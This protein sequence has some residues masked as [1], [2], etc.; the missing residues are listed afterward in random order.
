MAR[1]LERVAWRIVLSLA[2]GTGLWCAHVVAASAQPLPFP[3]GYNLFGALTGWAVAMFL[4]ALASWLIGTQPISRIGVI[5]AT[6]ILAVAIELTSILGICAIGILPGPLWKL[7]LIGLGGVAALVGAGISLGIVYVNSQRQSQGWLPQALAA[8]CLGLTVIMA[9]HCVIQAVDWGHHGY[10]KFDSQVNAA[11]LAA[12]ASVGSPVLLITLWLGLLIE[13]R[14]RTSLRIANLQLQRNAF[15]DLLTGLPNRLALENLLGEAAAAAD[16]HQSQL[17]LLFINLDAFKPI[18]EIYGHHGGDSVLCEMASRLRSVVGTGDHLARL[19]GD[20]FLLLMTTDVTTETASARARQ[21]LALV[22]KPHKFEGREGAIACS[23][24]IA[25]YPTHGASSVL[26]A[27][28]D[29]AMRASKAAGGAVFSFF[30]PRMLNDHREQVELLQDLRGAL[31]RNEFELFY[32]PKIDAPSGQITGAEALL[33]WVHPERGMISPM[34]FIPAAEKYGLINSIGAW[35]LEEACRQIAAWRKEGL[36][37]RVA[38]NLSVHQLR[39]T[40]LPDRISESLH[41]HQINPSL[42]TC[43]I[44]ESVAMEDAAVTRKLFE[45]LAAVGVH[46]SIDDFGTGYSSLSYLRT[47]PAGELKIDRS[48]VMD[49]ETSS[50]ARAV[51]N[52]V[53]KLAQALSLKVVAEGV[54][55]N[56]QNQILRSL[57]CDQLQGYFFAKPMRAKALSLWATQ[58]EGPAHIDFRRSLFDPMLPP[59]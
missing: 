6:F 44:T 41:R 33:R 22:S 14:L 50:D 7:S 23:I 57:G 16:Y 36:W 18:N 21:I 4:S 51:V 8:L 24:G 9:Q 48:F 15:T 54:E 40:D 58:S 25:T 35:V 34:I 19:G 31:G 46:I 53:I 52:A 10:S 42:L 47:L 59:V 56:G 49:L 37:M 30:E 17:A 2:M 26:I 20:E 32:Q 38:V 45:R 11:I 55:T 12:L 13:A 28:A 29:A 27:R 5:G 3:V 1:D 43:E 39:Q